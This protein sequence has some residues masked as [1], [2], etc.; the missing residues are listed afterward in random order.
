MAD[1]IQ[2]TEESPNSK[3][4]ITKL[5]ARAYM[6]DNFHWPTETVQSI[7]AVVE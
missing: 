4:K 3:A 6:I 7:L 1:I 2:D 5:E